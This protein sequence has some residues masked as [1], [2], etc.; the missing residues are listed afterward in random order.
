VIAVEL[1][2]IGVCIYL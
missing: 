2:A 1:V